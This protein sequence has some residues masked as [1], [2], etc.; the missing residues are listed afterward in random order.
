MLDYEAPALAW[1][2][3]G[4]ATGPVAVRARAIVFPGD[5]GESTVA[6]VAEL[7]GS[8]AS[9]LPDKAEAGVLRQDFTLLA[10]VRDATGRVVHKS[11]GRYDLSWPRSKEAEVKKG[12]VLFE[13]EAAL[14]PGRYTVETV[15]WD[16]QASKAGVHRGPLV[17]PYESPEALRLSP[18]VVVGHAE[19]RALGSASPLLYQGMLLYPALG[20]A[21]G[22]GKPLAFLFAL[23]GHGPLPQANVELA[24]G[25]EIV[26]RAQVPLPAADE[27]GLVRVVGALPVDGLAPG[28]YALRLVLSDG[29]SMTTRSADV[30]LAP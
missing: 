16:A 8:S 3:Q 19:K 18:L 25:D 29:R 9:L 11:S 27:S 17:V 1:A 10:L 24:H 30:T 6:L 20:E 4:H 26:R 13:R 12:R 23:R 21:V 5:G 15:V 22:G 7:P 28:A 14:P 2:E